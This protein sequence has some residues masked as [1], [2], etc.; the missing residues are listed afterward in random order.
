MWEIQLVNIYLHTEDCCIRRTDVFGGRGRI[1]VGKRPVLLLLYGQ[2]EHSKA[3]SCGETE[4]SGSA[5]VS[6]V[7]RMR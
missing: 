7:L 2:F 3:A 5:S 4:Q 1:F 6:K